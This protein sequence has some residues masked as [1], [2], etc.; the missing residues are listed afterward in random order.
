VLQL[1]QKLTLLPLCR[2]DPDLFADSGSEVASDDDSIASFDTDVTMSDGLWLGYIPGN[3]LAE[4]ALDLYEDLAP[5]ERDDFLGH[6]GRGSFE[7]KFLVPAFLEEVKQARDAGS[8]SSGVD[9]AGYEADSER[10]DERSDP[11]SLAAAFAP[12]AF[13]FS[14]SAAAFGLSRR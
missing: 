1:R 7:D 13:A 11:S 12:P 2:E 10:E 8:A 4:E 5:I 14:S 9:S 6:L 3:A